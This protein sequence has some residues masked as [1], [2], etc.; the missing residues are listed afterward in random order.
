MARQLLEPILDNGVPNPF[1]FEGRLLTAAALRE[2]QDAHR[3]RQAHLGRALGHGVVHGLWVRLESAGS[4]AEAPRLSINAGLAINGKGQTLELPAREVVALARESKPRAEATGLF[5]TCEPPATQVEATGEGFYVLVLAPASGFRGRA[6]ASGL[7][8]PKAGGGCGSRWAVEGVRLRLEPIDPLAVAELSAETRQLL[9]D[10]L[11][12]ATGEAGR[13]RLRNVVAHLCL[14]T[15]PLAGFAADPF[16]RRSA[17]DGGTEAALARYGAL[18]DLA[19]AGRLTDCDVPLA[20]VLWRTGGVEFVDNWAVRR[21]LAPPATA[22]PWPTLSGGRRRA[23][24]EATLFQ[25]QEQIAWLVRRVSNPGRIRARQYFRWLPPAG[26]VPIAGGGR[27]GVA[28]ATFLDGVTT[29]EPRIYVDGARLRELVET[30]F[31]QP[32]V[33]PAGGEFLWTYRVRQN[34]RLPSESGTDSPYLVFASGH[35]PYVGTARFDVARWDRA[36]YENL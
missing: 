22:A 11:L 17:P 31:G 4:S 16:A 14:G 13:S 34:H 35:M 30:S 25:F 27:R 2:D 21:R 29:R 9:Q 7:S 36:N 3:T 6:P 19:A 18:D 23:E 8:E 1:Y 24:A 33:D 10:E 12:G 15:E 5:R 32:P 20:L 26:L 28:A